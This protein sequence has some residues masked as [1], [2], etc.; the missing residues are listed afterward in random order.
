MSIV[1]GTQEWTVENACHT[2]YR[3]GTPIPQVTDNDEWANLTTGAWCYHNNDPTKGIL[4]NWYAVMGIHDN[5]PNTQNKQFAPDGWH[6]PTGNEWTAFQAYLT[7]NGYSYDGT[8]TTGGNKIAKSMASTTG[9]YS[10]TDPGAPG[11]NQS[12]N[13]SSGF[14]AF[15]LG[16]R[17][18]NYGTFA[19]EGDHAV[20]WSSTTEFIN[21][22]VVYIQDRGFRE[23]EYFGYNLVG[24]TIGGASGFSVR[25]VKD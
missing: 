20:F 21:D 11:N 18:Y 23:I 12:L 22:G 25:L 15:P 6:V 3:D 1:Y 24:G 5:D 4:Y 19:P 2:I 8:T 13:N 14:N 7:A 17:S 9:W 16:S 10:S